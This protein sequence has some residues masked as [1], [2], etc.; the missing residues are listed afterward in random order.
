MKNYP[1]PT[2]SAVI[3]NPQGKILLCK[4]HKWDD[5]YVIPGGHIELGEKMEDALK[6]EIKEETGLEIFDIKLISL[7]ESIYSDK[8]HDKKHFIFIDYKCKT[9]SSNVKLNNEAEEYIWVDLKDIDNYD[10][11]G[12][13]KELLIRLK[14][15]EEAENKVCIFYN[16]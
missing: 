2:V 16:Y 5:K 3:F 4:S 7:K 14:D 13:L 6:R 11:G 1:E 9:N 12:F 10:L 15:R 8:F